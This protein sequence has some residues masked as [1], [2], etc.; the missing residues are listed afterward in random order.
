MC[1]QLMPIVA[2]MCRVFF[3]VQRTLGMVQLYN[4]TKEGTG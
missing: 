1:Q 3:Y 4:M 2:D